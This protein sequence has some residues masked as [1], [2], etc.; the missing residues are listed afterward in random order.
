MRRILPVLFASLLLFSPRLVADSA[1]THSLTRAL[2]H[3]SPSEEVDV[4]E[5]AEG[6]FV[7]NHKVPVPSNSL[8]VFGSLGSCLVVDT[9]WT[10]AA[11]Q[12]EIDWITATTG[13]MPPTTAVSTHFHLDRLGGNA[14]LK[15]LGIPIH[16]SKMTADILAVAGNRQNDLSG[17]SVEVTPPDHLF[18]PAS[19]ETLDFDGEPVLLLYPGPGHTRDN[20]VVY[21]PRRGVLF[22]GCLVKCLAATDRG[23][24]ADADLG[25]WAD[26]VRVLQARFPGA[27]VVVP[28]HGKT[29]GPELLAHTIELVK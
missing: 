1:D 13:S 19:D 12:T 25:A 6:V 22:A 21:L 11:T 5:V 4:D 16:G 29:G 28:G 26:T 20:I 3:W 27:K 17:K 7:V 24:T 15:Q 9:P 18:D 8:I 23:N 2:R 14:L 10:V